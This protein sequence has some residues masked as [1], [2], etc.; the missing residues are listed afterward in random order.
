MLKLGQPNEIAVR[1]D[2]TRGVISPLGGD[3]T[4]FGGLY[5]D[6]SLLVTGP[7][8]ITPL[9]YASPGVYLKPISV[10]RDRAD[11][12]VTT[13]VS[14]RAD[15]ERYLD[16]VTSF[17]NAQGRVV[18]RARSKAMIK[19]GETQNLVQTISIR[20]PH[21]WNGVADP[22]LYTA[23]V[24]L[25]DG[26]RRVDEVDQPLGPRFFSVDPSL[27]FMLNGRPMQI[28]GVCRH[29]D[30]AGTGWA[31][32]EKQQE[33]DMAIMREMGVNGVR[34]AHYQHNPYFYSLCDKNGVLA[35]AELALV[36]N[37]RNTDDFR[38]DVRQQLTELIR[39]NYNHPSIVM[40]SMYNEVGSRGKDKPGAIIKELSDLSHQ[41]D[42]T[43]PTTGAASGDTM[44]NLPDVMQAV[45]LISLNIYS[46]WYGGM[47][48]DLGREIDRYNKRYG[49]KGVS[50]SEYGAGASIK[51]HQEGMSKPPNPNSHFHPEEWQAILHEIAYSQI[52]S[53]PYVWGSFLWNIFDFASAGRHEGDADGINDK[54][55]VTRDRK[56][57]K[58]AFYF[59]KA[60]W[61]TEPMVYI[62]SRR[63]QDRTSGSIDVKV[64]SNC[65]KVTV[66]INGQSIGGVRTVSDHVFVLKGVPLVV[67]DN[68]VEVEGQANDRTVRDSCI[69]RYREIA[70]TPS[71]GRPVAVN[72]P[73]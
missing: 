36:N 14:N 9:D 13:K 65:P 68:T 1:V 54:G 72:E 64:Y 40:W 12:D 34:L 7:I 53:R 28:H 30:W 25:F 18:A 17:L 55:L 48:A 24:E 60:N 3:F 42:P 16:V 22:Y 20:Y 38:A 26:T 39:Q 57:K 71:E 5:R 41:E 10:T 27:G 50:V 61:T 37:V 11:V 46:G 56:V 47:P 32:S 29:Q 69:W 59:Y 21:L 19:P 44:A 6:V 23:R 73:R 31:I 2:N 4:I 70:N 35:W 63:D 33:T 8:A 67:G 58:D 52:E 66:K 51:Q 45:D 15:L 43:R 62:T 49:S